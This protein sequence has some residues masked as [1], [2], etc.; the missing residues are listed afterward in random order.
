MCLNRNRYL[1]R[2]FVGMVINFQL[3]YGARNYSINKATAVLPTNYLLQ[4]I[5][6]SCT[7]HNIYF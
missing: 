4:R 2:D 7:I 6:T 3:S 1:W 5:N